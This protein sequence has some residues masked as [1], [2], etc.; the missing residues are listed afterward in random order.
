LLEKAGKN[1]EYYKKK[2]ESQK[3]YE[4]PISLVLFDELG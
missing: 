3:D 2:K 4:L 1:L